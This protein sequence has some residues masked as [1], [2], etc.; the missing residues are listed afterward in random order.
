MATEEV[1]ENQREATYLSKEEVELKEFEEQPTNLLTG[2][3]G[4]ISFRNT[5]GRKA[6][7]IFPAKLF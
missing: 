6:K 2:D 1:I 7:V 5:S 3:H 4:E